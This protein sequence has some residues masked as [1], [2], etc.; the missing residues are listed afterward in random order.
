MKTVSRAI[1]ILGL[2]IGSCT[3][4][5]AGGITW[6]FS[7]VVF[8][9]GNSVTG[10]FVTD[11]SITTI[12]SFSIVINGTAPGAF[13]PALMVD[14]YLPGVIGIANSGFSEY[15]DLYLTSDLTSAGGT[16]PISSGFDCP[17]G[18]C[19]VLLTGSGYDPTVNGVAT[20]ATP[21]PSAILLLGSGLG[22]LGIG[23]RRNLFGNS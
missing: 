11:S 20:A 3:C 9:N 13:T 1:A 18:T 21:E 16:V 23:L 12:E 5:M 19:G 6:T 2:L 8:N 7:D 10:S 17:T 22:F 15:V 4:A 14:S